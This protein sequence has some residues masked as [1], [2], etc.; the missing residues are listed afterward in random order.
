MAKRKPSYARNASNGYPT[1]IPRNR[2][3]KKFMDSITRNTITFGFGSAGSGKTFIA[4]SMAAEAL[5]NGLCRKIVVCRPI[6]EA[7]GERLGFLPGTLEEKCS[8][9]LQPIFDVFD[10]FW[11]KNHHNT[12]QSL[13]QKE[14]IQIA[15]LAY[16]RGRNLSD[17]WVL[18]D[19]AQN[20]NSDMMKMLLSRTSE[21]TKV[22]ITGDPDQRD[23]KNA[24]GFE[25]AMHSLN[26]CPDV[27]FVQFGIRDVERSKVVQDILQRW[28]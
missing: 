15:P 26:D 7:G 10:Q 12:L 28:P 19:E 16:M 9:Y 6:V 3:Q 5:Q 1:L 22:I 17:C 8:P 27:G 4:A 23:N 14:T 11:Y 25:T 24:D 13:L 21:N 20:M 18:C 2:N